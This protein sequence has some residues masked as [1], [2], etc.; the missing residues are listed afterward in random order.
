M[1]KTA[2]NRK[3][4]R[5]ANSVTTTCQQKS[6]HVSVFTHSVFESMIDYLA[7]SLLRCWSLTVTRWPDG[8]WEYI[9]WENNGEKSFDQIELSYIIKH[10]EMCL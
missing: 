4:L 8:C 9:R 1:N 6:Q 3:T 2:L 5:S 7:C 10:G